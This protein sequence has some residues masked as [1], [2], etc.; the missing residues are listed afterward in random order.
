MLRQAAFKA[1][2]SRRTRVLAAGAISLIRRLPG[3]P[4]RREASIVAPARTINRPPVIARRERLRGRRVIPPLRKH[5]LENCDEFT[6]WPAPLRA[7]R[8]DALS[9]L[10][11]DVIAGDRGRRGGRA[12]RRRRRP[13]LRPRPLV[14]DA[15]RLLPRRRRSRP[16]RAQARLLSP[17][18]KS[19]LRVRRAHLP[20]RLRAPRRGRQQKPQW[21]LQA[22]PLTARSAAVRPR[23]NEGTVKAAAGAKGCKGDF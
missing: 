3:A 1:R 16:L 13:S 12:V 18:L 15:P 5:F 17:E 9:I 11:R 19:G 6:P 22:P 7:P 23:L 10:H 4:S 8:V 21:P 2:S 14:R 20:Q